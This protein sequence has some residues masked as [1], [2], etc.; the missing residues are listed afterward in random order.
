MVV[1]TCRHASILS[2]WKISM[3]QSLVLPF[4]FLSCF[5]T[6]ASDTCSCTC[7]ELALPSAVV[8]HQPALKPVKK[9][10]NR[11][12]RGCYPVVQQSAAGQ[13]TELSVPSCSRPSSTSFDKPMSFV[14]DYHGQSRASSD[15]FSDMAD[16]LKAQGKEEYETWIVMEYCDQGSLQGAI[17]RGAFFDDAEKTRPRMVDILL[18]AL[19]IAKGMEHLHSMSIVHGAFLLFCRLTVF[20]VS[21]NN[22]TVGRLMGA[23]CAAPV[24]ILPMPK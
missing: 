24:R 23:V 20:V 1:V 5:I 8:S 22:A 13:L 19:D 10:E 17:Q 4:S 6:F 16:V 11:G 14:E 3:D 7:M 9:A 2:Q 12:F 21:Q 15:C 18:T